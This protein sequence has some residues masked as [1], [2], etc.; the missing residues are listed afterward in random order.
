MIDQTF[1]L[2]KVILLVVGVGLTVGIISRLFFKNQP[3]LIRSGAFESL[4]WI[5]YLFFGA[6]M[7]G[8]ALL[9][10]LE[11]SKLI[12]MAFM[13]FGGL[14]ILVMVRKFKNRDFNS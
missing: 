7:F 3:N 6:L 12:A 11:G 2:V 8:L 5:W 14:E 9:S 13:I 4:G 1:Q 10:W